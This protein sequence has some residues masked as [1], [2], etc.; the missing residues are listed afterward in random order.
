MGGW[1]NKTIV[2]I[3]NVEQ[4]IKTNT[5]KSREKYPKS[6]QEHDSELKKK[7]GNTAS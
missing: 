7:K 1:K 4:S 3:V 2:V 6:Y 5:S